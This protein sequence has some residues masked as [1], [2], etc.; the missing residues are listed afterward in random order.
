MPSIEG[1]SKYYFKTTHL[2]MVIVVISYEGPEES[3]S[4]VSVEIFYI[5]LP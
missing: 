5:S 4:V 1:S 3:V 2:Q